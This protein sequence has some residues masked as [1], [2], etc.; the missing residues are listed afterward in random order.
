LPE[1]ATDTLSGDFTVML[2]PGK[3]SMGVTAN[4]Y[5]AQ[6]LAFPIKDKQVLE[7]RISLA[8]AAA[9]AVP[10]TAP[11][12][13]TVAPKIPTA[14]PEAPT[15]APAAPT[16]SAKPGAPRPELKPNMPVFTPE[17]PAGTTKP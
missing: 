10:T 4:G 1:I 15:A 8:P 2:P 6:E 16:S 13:P 3:Y 12:V 7:Q 5:K 17:T 9:P 14:A 11:A